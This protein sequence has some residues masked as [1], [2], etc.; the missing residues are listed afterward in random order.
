M[1][2]R[3]FIDRPVFA[4]VLSIVIVI[5]GGV[6]LIGMP[7]E[8]YPELAPPSVQVV[9]QYPGANAQTVALTVAAPL[10]QEVNGVD[11][12]LYMNSTSTDGQY[13]LDVTFETGTNID[14][15]AVLV[16]NRVNLAEPRLPEEARRQGVTVQKQSSAF[17]GVI[18][19]YSPEGDYDD[20]FL[21]NYLTI[22]WKDEFSRIDGVGGIMIFPAKDYAMRVW[23]DPDR[24]KARNLTVN[25][26]ER[27]IR[28]QNVQVAAGKIGSQPAPAGTDFELNITT[29]GRLE[30]PEEFGAIIIRSE[31]GREVRLRDVATVELGA[32]DYGT[33]ST[34]NGD[35]TAV[36]VI[37]QAPGANLVDLTAEMTRVLERLKPA[38]PAGVEARFFYDSSMFIRA[39]L[40]EVV[41]TLIEAFLL[42]FLVVFLFLQSLR[43]TLIPAI[44]IPVSLIGAFLFM[45]AMGFSINMLTMFGMVLAIGI[46]V[47][48]AIVVV[49]NVERNM[50][51][52]HLGARD[53]TIRAMGEIFGPIISI[54]L[55]LMSVFIPTAFLPGLTG[56]MYRQFA[57]TIAA[58]TGLS[59]VCAL[60]LSPALCAVFLKAT[61]NPDGSRRRGFILFRPL[62][63]L[64][65]AFNWVFGRL[66]AAYTWFTR[67]ACRLW[68]VT[69]LLFLGVLGATAW[70]Y[71]RVPQGFVPEEDLGFVMVDFQL[72]DGASLQRTREVVERVAAEVQEVD[73]VQDITAIGGFSIINGQ[74]ARN[75]VAWIVLDPWDER[76]RTHRDVNAV[77]ADISARVGQIQ[78]A[79]FLAFAMPAIPGIGNA[80]GFDMRL[81][82]RGNVGREAMERAVWELTGAA[83][84]Q[85]LPST[86]RP[87]IMV[88]F[89]SYRAAVPQLFLD[90]DREKVM[91]MGVP[92]DEVFAALQASMGASYVNDFNAFSRTWQVNIQAR[93][94]QRVRAEDV[95]KLEVRNA[96]GD[97]VPLSTFAT[98]RDSHGPD[99]VTRYNLYPSAQIN[100]MPAPGVSSGDAMRLA[101]AAAAGTLPP[102]IGFEWTGLSYQEQLQGGQGPLVFGLGILLVYL[103]L[104]A[105][106]ESWTTPLAV[107]LSVPLVVVGAIV[108]LNIRHLDNNVFTQIGLVLLIGL[109]A[110]NAILIVEFAREARARGVRIID[111][112]V[113]AARTRFRPIV[114]T[115]L[116][117]ILGVT[118]LL[119]AH[120]AGAG[121]RQSL[122]TAVFGGM[123]GVTILGLVFTP[124][125]Y[126]MVTA[127]T[128]WVVRLAGR[129]PA[130]AR[131]RPASTHGAIP[132]PASPE[133]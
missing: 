5:L 122:G 40:T 52:H 39:S 90:I 67:W 114:M 15:A 33:Y 91:R 8:Q 63:W 112:A 87:G 55:V 41:K 88:A 59:A 75:G 76:V 61:H 62:R 74:S 38:L 35:P 80:A 51:E 72:P 106:Y 21:A 110:K 44:T 64:G 102:G 36:L 12:M 60:T 83:M 129:K 19:L 48:D 99:A 84:G 118:P 115:S 68:P 18:S 128:E 85:T 107:V 105:Q 3:F 20:L 92:L 7:V 30:T 6:A 109:G 66:T 120:G 121:S 97:M 77:L 23:L 78:E 132:V 103:I 113:S 25:D 13:T 31:Q 108:A 69:A 81:Q 53:A 43:T 101:E 116:A 16:Q 46:V 14:M 49:E 58:S 71:T 17:A 56:Q 26:V 57:L 127:T 95:L 70:L 28:A 42:V 22:N 79:Q 133:D 32:R 27:A 9:A 89:S 82:D 124:A 45:A 117:F 96:G 100:G 123:I 29:L 11:G 126:V 73:G 130:P 119:N 50:T 54:T 111:A 94:D 34:F 65:D 131:A 93:P 4:S 2:S 37:M 125:L 98:I 10:E 1:F 104:A 24:L 86:G 47:D